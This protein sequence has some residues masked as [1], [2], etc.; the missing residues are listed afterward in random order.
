MTDKIEEMWKR[1]CE[2]RYSVALNVLKEL[3]NS[4]PWRIADLIE[5]NGDATEY[6]LYDAGIQCYCVFIGMYLK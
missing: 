6:L 5:A 2:S 4:M 3:D 1:V